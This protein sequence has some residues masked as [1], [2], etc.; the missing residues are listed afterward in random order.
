[1]VDKKKVRQKLKLSKKTISVLNDCDLNMINGGNDPYGSKK[2]PTGLTGQK[3]AITCYRG[4]GYTCTK[5]ITKPGKRTYHGC[6][7]TTM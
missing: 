7:Y 3:T 5:P 1:M 6:K 2:C 4:T